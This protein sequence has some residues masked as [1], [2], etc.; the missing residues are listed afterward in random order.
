MV[1]INMD[2]LNELTV[3][4]LKTLTTRDSDKTSLVKAFVSSQER[5]LCAYARDGKKEV[6]EWSGHGEA[7]NAYTEEA[8]PTNKCRAVLNS[9]V[10]KARKPL[11][12]KSCCSSNLS[13]AEQDIHAS[14]QAKL[15]I[16]EKKKAPSQKNTKAAV[17][18]K[19]VAKKRKSSRGPSF[20]EESK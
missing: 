17:V 15:D 4:A 6:D 13:L 19:G 11:K 14:R 5:Y 20:V 2:T 3:E 18:E 10:L 16:G 1:C 7:I 8:N 9:P 12:E